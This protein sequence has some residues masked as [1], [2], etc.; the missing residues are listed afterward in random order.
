MAFSQLHRPTT[1]ASVELVVFKRC[2]RGIT[3]RAPTQNEIASNLTCL[4]LHQTR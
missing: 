1:S 2:L 4:R 3:L